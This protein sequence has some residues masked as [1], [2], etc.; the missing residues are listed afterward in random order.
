MIKD[1]PSDEYTRSMETPKKINSTL[2]MEHFFIRISTF[3]EFKSKLKTSRHLAF[4]FILNY[5]DNIRV[6]IEDSKLFDGCNFSDFFLL[7]GNLDKSTFYNS[8]PCFQFYRNRKLI[9]VFT[10]DESWIKKINSI[11]EDFSNGSLFE[12]NFY[13]NSLSNYLTKQELE[14]I[15]SHELRKEEKLLKMLQELS[16][17]NEGHPGEERVLLKIF[18]YLKNHFVDRVDREVNKKRSKFR[19]DSGESA[20]KSLRTN[21]FKRLDSINTSM[22]TNRYEDEESA[23]FLTF[24]PK[25]RNGK[26]PTKEISGKNQETEKILAQEDNI[27]SSAWFEDSLDEI[28]GYLLRRFRIE[29]ETISPNI[30][31]SLQSLN[32]V[33]KGTSKAQVA[34]SLN[35]GV[36]GL[37]SL[38]FNRYYCNK[39]TN[40]IF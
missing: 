30:F 6:Q 5:D 16:T 34:H 35:L 9:S 22:I 37:F 23:S 18:D 28:E 13:L 8:P 21:S 39:I 2:N 32:T 19:L 33:K 27:S 40:Q 1:A 14:F 15:A 25:N 10:F 3:K 24:S 4:L 17:T 36:K 12:I 26:T 11:L 29:L 20:K 31:E 38:Q 7:K